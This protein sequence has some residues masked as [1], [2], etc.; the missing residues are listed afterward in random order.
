M[1]CPHEKQTDSCPRVAIVVIPQDG[2]GS[3]TM[4]G[5]PPESRPAEGATPGGGCAGIAKSGCGVAAT[6][7]A[8]AAA[9]A[10]TAIGAATA[11]EAPYWWYPPAGGGGPP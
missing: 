7:G 8:T 5:G 3:S 1:G 4:G 9:T 11:G 2:H 6:A 10:A